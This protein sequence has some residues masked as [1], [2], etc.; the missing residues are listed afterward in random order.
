MQAESGGVV[1]LLEVIQSDFARL[2]AETQEAE[3]E[4]QEEFERMTAE[5]AQDKA[6][7]TTEM[8]HKTTKN[9]ELE[10]R[11][12]DLKSD[13]EGTQQELDAALAYYE[14]LKPSCIDVGVSYEERVAAR[15]EEIESLQEALSILQGSDLSAEPPAEEATFGGSTG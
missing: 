2:L 7:K 13:L 4:A 12:A 14:K 3:N 6:V 11:I 15:K 10:G 5:M 1:G 9:T 8:D